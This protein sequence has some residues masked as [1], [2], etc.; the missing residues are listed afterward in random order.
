MLERLKYLL[1]KEQV[2]GLD[3]L[4]RYELEQLKN[5]EEDK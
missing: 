4:E 5:N 3:K 1:E 2:A